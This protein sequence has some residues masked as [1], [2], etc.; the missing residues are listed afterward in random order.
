MRKL[1]RFLC[2]LLGMM[3]AC[4]TALAATEYTLPEKMDMQIRSGSG[5]RGTVT[6]AVAGGSEWLDLLLPFT[7][8]KVEVRYIVKDDRFE[9]QIYALDDQE[10]QRALTQVYGDASHMYFRSELLPGTVLSLP[11]GSDL[12]DM[13]LGGNDGNPT[14]YNVVQNLMDIP[15]EN[16]EKDWTPVV[17]RY[18]SALEQWL[19]GFAAEPSISQSESGSSNMTLRYVIPSGALKAAMKDL[20]SQF[21]SDEELLALMRPLLSEAQQAVYLNP[22]IGYYYDAVIDAL[23]LQGDLTMV[24]V[25]SAKGEMLSSS[26][27][28][29]LPENPNG[30]TSLVC[31]ITDLDTSLTLQGPAQTITLVA[32][33]SASARE[34]TNTWNGIFR[35]LPQEGTA[36]SAAFSLSKKLSVSTDADT[37]RRHETTEWSLTARRDLNHLSADDASRENYAD[38]E[39]IALTF[40]T[41]YS[42]REQLNNPTSLDLVLSAQLP[43]L[44]LDMETSLRT[45][46]LWEMSNLPTEGSESLLNLTPERLAELVSEFTRNAALT[47]MSLT[48]QPADLADVPEASDAPSAEPT[49]VPPAK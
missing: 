35:Y 40:S 21:L 37:G 6:L 22:A 1:N 38:F 33:E 43:A 12:M 18:E 27:V 24:R 2:L 19:T 47:M 8:S 28:M 5:V 25:L 3:L 32:Q 17:E 10:Q 48:A 36:I 23:P 16:W 7:G 42:G 49:V 29:P 13:F 14:F 4:S 44:T 34:G 9:G 41:H 45:T 30:W 11:I 26:L 39:D 31:E 46:N 20:M 15:G